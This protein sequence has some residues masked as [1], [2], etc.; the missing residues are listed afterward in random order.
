VGSSLHIIRLVAGA[1]AL[2]ACS[3]GALAQ[4][5]TLNELRAKVFDARMAV[6]TFVNGAHHCNEL[7]GSNFYFERRNRVLGLQEF[8]QS[9][10]NLVAA[11]TFNPERHRPWSKEDAELRWQQVS[12]LASEE[13]RICKLIVTLPEL[14]H[15]LADIEAKAAD[16]VQDKVQD[17]LQDSSSHPGTLPNAGSNAADRTPDQYGQPVRN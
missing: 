12:R 6:K 9:L 14:E 16:R 13:L 7:N 8:R 17:K 4:G 5:S 10:D 1:A 11:Q 15:Q 3:V 2:V